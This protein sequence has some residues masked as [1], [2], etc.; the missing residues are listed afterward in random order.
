MRKMKNKKEYFAIGIIFAVLFV[1]LASFAAAQSATNNSQQNGGGEIVGTKAATVCCEKTKSGLFCQDVLTSEC[2]SDRQPPTACSSTSFCKTGWCYDSNEGTCLDNVPQVTCTENGGTWSVSKPAACNLGCCILDD[3]ASFVSLVRCKKLSGFYGLTTNWDQSI[4]NEPA[5]ILAAGTQETGACVYEKDFQK[6]CKFTTKGACTAE[7]VINKGLTP[8]GSGTNRNPAIDVSGSGLTPATNS[9][10]PSS[11]SGTNAAGTTPTNGATTTPSP[12][13]TAILPLVSAQSQ[14]SGVGGNVTF[15]PGKLCSAEELGT[16]CA[17]TRSTICVPG[18][19][20]VYFVDSCGNPANI[21]DANKVNSRDYWNS[22][23]P[24]E[25]AC[26]PNSNNKDS[27][28]CG[29]CNYLLGSYCRDATK[30]KP[31]YGSFICQ[32]LNCNDGGKERINGE[33]WCVTDSNKDKPGSRYYREICSN[34]EIKTEACADFRQEECI[35]SN[36]AGYSQAACRVN[37]WQ[38]CTAQKNKNDCDNSD[39]RDCKWIQGVENLL[40][41][42]ALYASSS[43]NSSGA[44]TGTTTDPNGLGAIAAAAKQAGGLK[45][46]PQ[47]A[48]VPKIS[49]GF[50][51]SNNEGAAICAQANAACPVTYEKGLVGGSWKCV[52]HCECLPGGELEAKRVALCNSLGD[53]GPKVNFVGVQGSGK[54]YQVKTQED[55]SGK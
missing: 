21:Y 19:E 22:I 7:N 32:N 55:K 44:A 38:D 54:G 3:Q 15:Y 49:P 40:F 11:T 45:N 2:A 39:K 1:G 25:N 33:S 8:G 28:S 23:I 14:N 12:T 6:T 43:G 50:D 46:L 16:N 30:V 36:S 37:R 27:Q 48:C 47:G 31:T 52:E 17:P 41:G 13:A 18:K 5:C 34:G 51:Y 29:N 10:Q 4:T 20:E 26:S 35:E 9:P 24:K 42:G 53:C